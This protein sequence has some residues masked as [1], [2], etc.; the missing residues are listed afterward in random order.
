MSQFVDMLE[1]EIFTAEFVANSG[2]KDVLIKQFSALNGD[3][4]KEVLK[5]LSIEDKLM[6]RKKGL[7]PRRFWE[8]V[9]ELAAN[10]VLE[11]GYVSASDAKL[12]A[13][14]ASNSILYHCLC[15]SSIKLSED[16]KSLFKKTLIENRYLK[17]VNGQYQ[18]A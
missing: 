10:K 13:K 8:Q 14:T 7:L 15:D 6:M 11:G 5:T 18:K 1:K 12:L 17:N 9:D 2:Y 4:Q 16:D 3:T